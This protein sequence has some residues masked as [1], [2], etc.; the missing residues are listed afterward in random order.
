[1][2][3]N[4]DLSSSRAKAERA[5]QHLETLYQSVRASVEARAPLELITDFSEATGWMEFRGKARHGDPTLSVLL[6]EFLHDLRSGLDHAVTAIVL[7]SGAAL[8]R[9]HQFPICSSPAGFRSMAGT[10][11]KPAG[12]LAGITSGFAEI[13]SF[14]PYHAAAGAIAAVAL[15]Q[16]LSNSDKHRRLVEY[17][18]M[19]VRSVLRME[20][21]GVV[22]ENWQPPGGVRF[23]FR[24][25]FVVERVRFA[26]PYPRTVIPH[27]EL[28]VGLTFLDAAFPV[29]YP[30]DALFSLEQLGGVRDTVNVILDQLAAA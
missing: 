3:L 12:A 14:Q 17:A 23:D 30:T 19:P 15:L 10:K 25:E 29:E 28:G 1:M 8:T 21:D 20:T 24:D 2:P 26:Q 18:P 16:R 5:S 7:A 9:Q 27:L 11:R 6:G 4:P 22:V 13:E